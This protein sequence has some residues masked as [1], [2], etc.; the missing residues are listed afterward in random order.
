MMS[1]DKGHRQKGV[2]VPRDP[3]E[4]RLKGLQCLY[5]ISTII[6]VAEGDASSICQRVVELLPPAWQYP[7]VATARI[8]I[9]DAVY[10][11]PGFCEGSWSMGAPVRVS[12]EEVGRVEVFYTEARPQ[13]FEGPFLE[14]ERHLIDAVALHLARFI[15]QCEVQ[16]AMLREQS[17]AQSIF[18]HMPGMTYVIDEQGAFVRFNHTMES[19]TGLSREELFSVGPLSIVVEEDR[20]LIRERIGEV[21]EKGEASVEADVRLFSGERR[22]YLLT[23]KRTMMDGAPYLIGMGVDVTARKQAEYAAKHAAQEIEK[24]VSALD[25]RSR[26]VLSMLEDVEETRREIEAERQR[27]QTAASVMMEGIVLLDRHGEVVLSNPAAVRM[28]GL[29]GEVAI[30]RAVLDDCD[31]FPNEVVLESAFER[32]EPL[33]TD[34]VIERAPLMILRLSVIPIVNDERIGGALITLIDVTH[35]R[36]LDRAKDDLISTVSHELRTPLALI[37]LFFS[38]ADAGVMGKLGDRLQHGMIRANKSVKRLEILIEELLEYSRLSRGGFQ[39]RLEQTSLMDLVSAISEVYRP[40]MR[41]NNRSFQVRQEIS[42]AHFRADPRRLHQLLVNLL[43]NAIKF[44]AEGGSVILSVS[45]SPDW[46]EL[47]V[48]DNGIGVPAEY[49]ETVFERF[50][51]V[52]RE[53]GPG[54][55]GLGLGLAICKEIAHRHD[56]TIRLESEPGQGSAFVVTLPREGPTES[57]EDSPDEFSIA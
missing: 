44:T 43:D 46:V 37:K 24:S 55:K 22:T 21:F 29:K 32:V 38:N 1:N 11:S 50:Q 48:A 40:I 42:D 4:E 23:G 15:R 41:Q 7:E 30:T 47:R 25:E 14:E 27:F 26:A 56:G 20:E 35:V 10:E 5:E 12:G 18:E 2:G 3:T 16:R 45:D 8:R 36:E 54:A 51:Q 52:G 19:V 53:Y 28:L 49:Q 17:F 6:N 33:A 39:L 13:F 9:G 34:L 57:S 31:W